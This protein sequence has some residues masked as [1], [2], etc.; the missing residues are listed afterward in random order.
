MYSIKSN[1]L[2][3]KLDI[4]SVHLL[5][6]L[7]CHAS[8]ILFRPLTCKVC[9]EW[10]FISVNPNWQAKIWLEL[11]VSIFETFKPLNLIVMVNDSCCVVQ[12]WFSLLMHWSSDNLEFGRKRTWVYS[13]QYKLMNLGIKLTR[14]E[15]FCTSLWVG[16]LPQAGN[17]RVLLR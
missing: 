16:Y 7:L 4:K 6:E 10:F 2:K 14:T 11:K 9:D 5:L 17:L 12:H 3:W 15:G 13:V 8:S 1:C